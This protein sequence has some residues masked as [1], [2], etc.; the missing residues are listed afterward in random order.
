MEL[1][2]AAAAAAVAL[3]LAEEEA[4]DLP[5]L[6]SLSSSLIV[7]IIFEALCLITVMYCGG[8]TSRINFAK[9]EVAIVFNSSAGWRA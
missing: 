2:A 6:T 7:S 4:R 8:A 1:E 5:G 3:E 9:R